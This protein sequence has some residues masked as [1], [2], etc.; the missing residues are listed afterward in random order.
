MDKGRDFHRASLPK[1]VY[2]TLYYAD[3]PE[4]KKYQTWKMTLRGRER[5][6]GEIEDVETGKQGVVDGY[7]ASRHLEHLVCFR[8]R[9][10]WHWPSRLADVSNL[11]DKAVTYAG[12]ALVHACTCE[13]TTTGSTAQ[14]QS[15]VASNGPMLIVPAVL[16][17]ERVLPQNIVASYFIKIRSPRILS[18]RPTSKRQPATRFADQDAFERMPL[19]VR[20]NARG[21]GLYA[22]ERASPASA[23]LDREPAQAAS[24][25]SSRCQDARLAL[26]V[27][28]GR[29]QLADRLVVAHM[30]DLDRGGDRLADAHRLHE[31]PVGSRKTVPGPG[32]SSATTAFNRPVV[33]PPCT[34]RPPKPDLGELR[35]VVDRISVAG[36]FGEHLDVAHATWCG[37][38]APRRRPAAGRQIVPLPERVV[39]VMSSPMRRSVLRTR[40]ARDMIGFGPHRG[41]ELRMQRLDLVEVPAERGDRVGDVEQRRDSASRCSW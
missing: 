24:C 31:P 38:A 8:C 27:A 28:D 36:H 23:K 9:S 39:S 32:R 26:R 22:T 14:D 34:I 29:F 19:C 30:H 20:Q 11:A 13:V 33:T 18:G 2:V 35:I 6:H 25:R 5:V 1:P 7:S 4:G 41:A 3:E 10:A 15:A 12:L 21:V 40:Q 17:T 16:T 37:C